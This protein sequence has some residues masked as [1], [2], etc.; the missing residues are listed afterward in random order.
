MLW[1]IEHESI[2]NVDIL[3]ENTVT[4]SPVVV[5]NV[6]TSGQELNNVFEAKATITDLAPL[7]SVE[8]KLDGNDIVAYDDDPSYLCRIDTNLLSNGQHALTVI[9][10]NSVNS[11]SRQVSFTVANV[12][13]Q[14]PVM[15]WDGASWG[16][17]GAASLTSP[18][19]G[20]TISGRFI[21]GATV[22][23]N[24]QIISV[25]FKINDETIYPIAQTSPY[26][27]VLDTSLYADGDYKI[28]AIAEDAAGND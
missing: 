13:P 1:D 22:P 19:S 2:S 21:L 28:S 18:T 4:S 11:T 3:V 16:V 23:D 5:I 6:P 12:A 8:F 24:A 10:R 26:S 15:A 17:N 9:A 20:M 27:V 25:Q 14:I 7:T